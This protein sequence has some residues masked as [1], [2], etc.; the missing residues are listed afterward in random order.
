MSVTIILFY[1]FITA[2]MLLSYNPK[3]RKILESIKSFLL[4][5]VHL[6]KNVVSTT[7]HVPPDAMQMD[8]AEPV[9]TVW[10]IPG[11]K[12][13]PLVGTRWMYYVGRY[14]LN[15]MQD[16]FVDL[17]KRYGNIVLE[18]DHV[19]IVNLF[20][21]VDMEKV[22]K[23][24]SK[25]PYRPPTEIVEYYR[26]SRPDRFAST[27]IVNTNRQGEQWHELRV[28]LTSG[29]MSRKLLQ[30][31][32][33]TLNEI[34][35]EFVTLIRQK[36]DSNDCV[37]DFQDIA[38]T[39]GLEIIC[40]FVLGRR[41]GYMS[42]D[43]QKNEKF[44]KLAEAVKSTFMYISQS[45]YGVKLWKYL[46]TK[47]YRDYVRCEEIIYDTKL[48]ELRLLYS[49]IAEIVNEALAEEQEKCADDDMRGIF[50]NILQSEGLDKKD[51]IAGIID[52]I[53]AAIE[54]VSFSN[55][56]SFLLNNMTSHPERQAR[57]ASE[58]TSDTITNNDL[59]NA[60]F[61]RA[62]IKESYRISPTTPCLARILEEDFDL[63]GYQLKAGTVVLCHTRVACQNE[64]NFQQANTFLPERWLEQVDEN[65]N[66]YKLDEP[67]SSLVLPFGTGRR[68]CPG[69][70]IIE[71]ELTLIMAKVKIFQ[72]FKV[73][74]HSQLDTQFQ[75]L[76]APGTPIEIIFRDRD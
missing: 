69:N 70:K 36:R 44:V 45:Y 54:T 50:L 39:V 16:A 23:Y 12:R 31:F 19:P 76:L 15:K 28:K 52:L 42:G 65:Q 17:H 5:L 60:A 61:T 59:V 2:F 18:F 37:K 66:V 55:T 24:P 71:I 21:R 20:D 40:C 29:I 6:S 11:P 4:H 35:D 72:Q 1:V 46:P 75:F 74:Y 3:P 9:Y 51:K 63:S 64:Q 26:R 58:F 73:E 67:G 53:H 56:L 10:D 49:T 13:L 41:M 30:A 43:K 68:M 34:A 47:L 48:Y 38:N 62:C 7:I 25:Y 57:I 32:I 14:K 33:P 27:G 8:Q 22:L